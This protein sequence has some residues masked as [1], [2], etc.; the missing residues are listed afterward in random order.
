MVRPLR[1]GRREAEGKAEDL[2]DGYPALVPIELADGATFAEH[3]D[4]RAQISD[5]FHLA[6]RQDDTHPTLAPFHELLG[7]D[8]LR[9]DVDAPRRLVR[10]EDLDRGVVPPGEQQFL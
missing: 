10:Q 9:S 7:D 6:G 5:L 4:A 1:L 3:H 8:R 2:L